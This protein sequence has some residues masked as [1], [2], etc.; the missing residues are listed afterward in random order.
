[1]DVRDMTGREID[2]AKSWG[3]SPDKYLSLRDKLNRE[4]QDK[5]KA[6]LRED[7]TREVF[8]KAKNDARKELEND[9]AKLTPTALHR[10]VSTEYLACYEI[11][12]HTLA[13]TASALAEQSQEK[14][15]WNRRRLSVIWV[16]SVALVPAI[17]I[18]YWRGLTYNHL[19]FWGVI[20][21][22]VV[23]HIWNWVSYVYGGEEHDERRK[24]LLK[25]A[26]D[27]LILADSAKGARIVDIP[28]ADTIQT[29]Q[30]K[31]EHLA[32]M[33]RR[34]DDNFTPFTSA[35]LKGRE[36]AKVSTLATIDAQDVIRTLK[37]LQEPAAL[38]EHVDPKP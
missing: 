33:K 22:M 6:K 25:I 32:D 30:N 8:D 15:D 16:L 7:I 11:E 34:Q 37:E 21:P 29:I 12:C 19:A 20:V 2:E 35:I 26:S 1:M 5:D 18:L 27:Y 13:E 4:F 31:V 17:A 38:P 24:R 28:V 23:T 10:S 9:R 3:L 36:R 14:F